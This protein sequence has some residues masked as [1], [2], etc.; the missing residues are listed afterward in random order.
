M[1]FR[2]APPVSLDQIKVNSKV[3]AFYRWEDGY[4]GPPP[5]FHEIMSTLE[6][7]QV[8]CV[9]SEVPFQ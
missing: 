1:G 8:G 3:S 6:C 2:G 5:K 9:I 4:S 7:L